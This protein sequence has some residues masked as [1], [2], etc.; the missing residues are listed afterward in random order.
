[1]KRNCPINL[2]TPRP[3]TSRWSEC[4]VVDAKTST[5]NNS[6]VSFFTV[7]RESCSFFGH[8][9]SITSDDFEDVRFLVSLNLLIIRIL[10]N[11]KFLNNKATKAWSN[12]NSKVASG[13]IQYILKNY[14]LNFRFLKDT[15]A[16]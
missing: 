8:E 9:T 15:D 7:R 12:D 10:S 11:K 5:I 3:E 1:M 13:W 6:L 2:L 16:L 4:Q 14:L